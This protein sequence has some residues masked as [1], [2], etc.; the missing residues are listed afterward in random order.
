M[1]DL[2]RLSNTRVGGRLAATGLIPVLVIAIV[3]GAYVNLSLSPTLSNAPGSPL[4][5]CP[6]GVDESGLCNVCGPNPVFP[7]SGTCITEG[8][9]VNQ[10]AGVKLAVALN[11][12]E[13]VDYPSLNISDTILVSISEYN[14]LPHI[15]NLQAGKA[16][17]LKNLGIGGCNFHEPFG[18]AVYR[19]NYVLQNM[20]D[21]SSIDLFP[22]LSCPVPSLPAE[23]YSFEPDS[24]LAMIVTSPYFIISSNGSITTAVRQTYIAE[25]VAANIPLSGYCCRQIPF[26]KGAFTIGLVPFETGVYTL[27]AGDMW[28]DIVIFHFSVVSR[29]PAKVVSV[30]GPIP[31]Y[32]PGVPVVRVT[33]KNI[34]DSPIVSLNAT[35]K[36]PSAEPSITY[37]FSFGVNSTNRLLPGESEESTKTLIGAGFSNFSY[38]L[39]IRGVLA[40]NVAFNYTKL[41]VIEPPS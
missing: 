2:N 12:T 5:S 38:P 19:G 11:G 30:V 22:F 25:P 10:T 23:S 37:S 39:V 40:N 31:P 29:E 8:Q 28:G 27:A 6:S 3:F 18:I 14:I 34:G 36:L 13:L 4:S 33:L 16:W 26:G 9:A 15:N 1:H 35:L 41:V 21:A 7:S 32:N 24:N 17:P 20:S